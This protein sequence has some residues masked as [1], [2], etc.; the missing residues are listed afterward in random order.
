ME[1][2]EAAKA[3]AA[4]A[5][6]ERE[7]NRYRQKLALSVVRAIVGNGTRGG[8]QRARCGRGTGARVGAYGR[9]TGYQYQKCEV[10]RRASSPRVAE[11]AEGRGCLSSASPAGAVAV[12]A[13]RPGAPLPAD[14]QQT[15]C[16]ICFEEA[17]SILFYPCHPY[18]HVLTCTRCAGPLTKCPTC[19]APIVQKIRSF[20]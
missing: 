4:E 9:G 3:K 18:G 6:A 17:R 13:V 7:F 14:T 15:E 12:L 5:R 16:A 10:H 20:F 11:T 19:R 8:G 2:A 1:A